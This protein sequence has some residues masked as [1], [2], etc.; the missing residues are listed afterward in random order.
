MSFVPQES[1]TVDLPHDFIIGKSVDPKAACGAEGG[2]YPGAFGTY[3]R[4]IQF[5]AK[6]M[7]KRHVLCLDGCAGSAKVI[8]NGHLAARHHYAYTPFDVDITPYLTEGENRIAVVASNTDQPNARWYTGGGLYREVELLEGPMVHIANHGVFAYTR[9]ISGSA[10]AVGVEVTVENHSSRG[11]TVS[12]DVAIHDRV[13][14][15][16]P[17]TDLHP[18]NACASAKGVIWVDAGGS[19]VLRTQILVQNPRMW[20]LETPCLYE[21]RASIHICGGIHPDPQKISQSGV[22]ADETLDQETAVFGI[23]QITV[24][25]L[26]GLQLNGK[27]LKLKGGCIHHDNGIIGAAAW[28]DSEYRKV[29][30]HKKNGFMA[31]R[32]A[33]NPPSTELLNACDE[34]G[35]MVFNEAFDVWNMEKSAFDFSQHFASEWESELTNFIFRDRNHPCV[36]VWSVGN[37]IPEQGGLSEGYQTSA[38]LTAKTRQLD[39]TRPVGGALC[40]FFR[41]L[42]DADNA[43]YWQDIFAH[44]DELMSN[45][46]VNLDCP[47]GK[48]VWPYYT[49]PFAANWDIVGYNYLNYQY[50]P[51]HELFPTRVI[52]CTESKP[53]EL[54]PYWEDVQRLPYVIG[55]FEWTSMD[56]IGEAGIGNTQYVEK[57]EAEQA[58]MAMHFAQYPLRLAGSGDFDI[59]GFEKP[60]LA[61]RRIVWGSRETF[62]TSHNPINYHKT[63]LLGR[64]GWADCGHTWSWPAEKGTPIKL[65]VYSA[66][67]MVELIVNGVS[68]GTAPA[69]KENDFRGIFHIPYEP[70]RVEAISRSEE[71]DE[72][73][74]DKVLSAD[75]P[76][77]IRITE[78][79][80]LSELH[81]LEANR[82]QKGSA[83]R[84]LVIEIAD[85]NGRSVTYVEEEVRVTVEGAGKLLGLGTGRISTEENYASGVIKTFRGKALAVISGWEQGKTV[86]R[87]T[88]DTLPQAEMK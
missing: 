88:S 39:P 17:E 80:T 57:D 15:F 70:G 79:E 20:D 32:M 1:Q 75:A 47:F 60:Q 40:S 46:S 50:E 55:D 72:I 4:K 12:V 21:A 11:Q 77:Q 53:R 64:Y 59:C 48:S 45:G 74:R 33:H 22:T 14:P 52:C 63:E 58:M 65:E 84:Y 27:T 87:V 61:Y 31:L 71:G 44:R 24:D 13:N 67:P 28:H 78:D 54:V 23:R 7:E 3:T 8:V 82:Q 36:F 81:R 69:G 68:H 16:S 66:A 86:V 56:Y 37:E 5:S 18:E 49:A 10:A 62:I 26:K 38:M 2:F 29:L 85:Q 9:S 76:V 19:S 42:D 83:L 25:A 34:I 6:E 73:S 51:S 30:L 35:M 43:R 41:G